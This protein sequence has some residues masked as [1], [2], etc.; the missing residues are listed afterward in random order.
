LTVSFICGQFLYLLPEAWTHQAFSGSSGGWWDMSKRTDLPHFLMKTIHKP[1]LEKVSA[2]PVSAAMWFWT[3]FAIITLF[4][5]ASLG[6]LTARLWKG[7][8]SS[9]AGYSTQH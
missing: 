7:R 5:I 8:K 2:L 4:Q 6:T 9:L 3:G 1:F